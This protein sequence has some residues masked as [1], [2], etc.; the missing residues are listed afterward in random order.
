MS[1]LQKLITTERYN[2]WY[3]QRYRIESTQQNCKIT[4]RVF[5]LST[6]ER[7]ILHRTFQYK[8]IATQ[9]RFYILLCECKGKGMT[10]NKV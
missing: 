10:A 4:V 7:K 5:P 8:Y 1:L 9:S 3:K 6:R 2:I